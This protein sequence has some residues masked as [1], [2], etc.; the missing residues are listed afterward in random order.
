MATPGIP[1]ED[2]QSP[3]GEPMMPV[4]ESPEARDIS[5]EELIDGML[6]QQPPQPQAQQM[7]M[8]E[9]QPGDID[10]A[11]PM[12]SMVGKLA[13]RQAQDSKYEEYKAVYPELT[14]GEFNRSQFAE[15]K[16]QFAEAQTIL[17]KSAIRGAEVM[18][19]EQKSANKELAVQGP[20]RGDT[21][22]PVEIN[23]MEDA[24]QA[25]KNAA[26]GL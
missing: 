7:A 8:P 24:T 4:A 16:Q 25:A 2:P 12:G 26:R 17:K 1:V 6:A 20:S 22:T 19:E 10:L 14:R 3:I 15:H 13:V 9:M 21:S 11:T 23:T 18:S 5:T